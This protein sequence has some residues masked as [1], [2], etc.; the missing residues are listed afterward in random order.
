MIRTSFAGYADSIGYIDALY[1]RYLAMPHGYENAD[2]SLAAAENHLNALLA[3][4]DADLLAMISSNLGNAQTSADAGAA[5]D[6]WTG[7]VADY[8]ALAAATP[9]MPVSE[10]PAELLARFDDEE[11]MLTYALA[12]HEFRALQTQTA[13]EEADRRGLSY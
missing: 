1:A 8:A 10:T 5:L 4:D 2:L 11:H 3:Q 12:H 6:N 9:G 13:T 7:S